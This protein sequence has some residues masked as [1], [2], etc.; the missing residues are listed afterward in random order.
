MAN[1]DMSK[2]KTVQPHQTTTPQT[3]TFK[4]AD[5]SVDHTAGNNSL[6]ALSLSTKLNLKNFKPVENFQKDDQSQSESK[7]IFP[8][9]QKKTS[10]SALVS[11]VKSI[12]NILPSAGNVI[13]NVIGA[14]LHPIRTIK[15]LVKIPMG[16]GAE[17]TKA[18]LQGTSVGQKILGNLDKVRQSNGLPALDVVDGKM[19]VP[20][21]DDTKFIENLGTVVKDRYGSWSNIKKTLEED[22]AG[23]IAD[24]SSAFD[25]GAGALGETG[26]IS[27]AGEASE[28][29]RAFASGKSMLNEDGSFATGPAPK[30]SGVPTMGNLINKAGAKAADTNINPFGSKFDPGAAKAFK[31]EG[32]KPPISA[33]NKSNFVRGTEAFLQKGLFGSGIQKTVEDATSSITTK[34]NDIVDSIKPTKTMSEENIGKM[35]QKGIQEYED[36]FKMTQEKVYDHFLKTFGKVKSDVTGTKE[37][38][39]KLI[40][41]QGQSFIS[42][43]DPTIKYALNKLTGSDDPELKDLQDQIDEIN[44]GGM[45][46]KA[47]QQM[48]APLQK[49]LESKQQELQITPTFDQLKQSRTDL[50]ELLAKNPDNTAY[51]RLYGAISTDMEKSISDYAKTPFG[52]EAESAVQALHTINTNYAEGMNKIEGSIASSVRQMNPEQIAQNLINRN[53]AG[54]LKQLRSMIGDTKFNEVSKAWVRDLFDSSIKKDETLDVQKLKNKLESYDKETVDQILTPDKQKDLQNAVDQLDKYDAM[55][56]SLKA[57]QK[58]ATGSQTAFI[59]NIAKNITA[60]NTLVQAIFSGHWGLAAGILGE[61]G[62]EF[63]LAKLFNSE[64]GTKIFTT[65]WKPEYLS[66]LKKA[67]YTDAQINTVINAFRASNETGEVQKESSTGG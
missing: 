29:E 44:A 23:V 5:G 52:K 36:N 16:L 37:M 28:A 19:I 21:D 30:E 40:A 62:G 47:K 41:E 32:I 6:A 50:G 24:L 55:K 61:T 13:S 35:V 15:G 26:V 9:F 58:M 11:G 8:T 10:D 12:A 60:L 46:D 1:L 63:L 20:E 22:P 49:Q 7:G 45:S 53:S 42:K 18:F 38:L 3:T 56:N 59:S 4:G 66:A 65:G 34:A 2:F 43:I 14:V 54:M 31:S 27:K 33:V 51:K 64:L 48:T 17:G 57:G 25:A 39:K 67:N